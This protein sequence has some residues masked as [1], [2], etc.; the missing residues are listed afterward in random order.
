MGWRD[1]GDAVVY[2]DGSQVKPP[3]ALCELQGYVFDAWMRM[4]E[5]FA[6]TRGA[7]QLGADALAQAVRGGG[8]S[9]VVGQ[10]AWSQAPAG[11]CCGR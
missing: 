4:A 8:A 7:L 6:A 2:P 3:K 1:A 5:L 9:G 10:G 11:G